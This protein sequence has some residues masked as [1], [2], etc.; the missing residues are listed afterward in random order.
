MSVP[1]PTPPC[2]YSKIEYTSR[3]PLISG[4]N[5]RLKEIENILD[6]RTGEATTQGIKQ[7]LKSINQKLTD[8]RE[9]L[10]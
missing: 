5:E 9:R 6:S 4:I 2:D 8:I 7:D 1:A 3:D 10:P